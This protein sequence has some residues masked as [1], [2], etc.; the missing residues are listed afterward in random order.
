MP[1]FYTAYDRPESEPIILD[2]T[3]IT[4]TAGYRTLVQMIAEQSIAGNNLI[5]IRAA[6]YDVDADKYVEDGIGRF[7][8]DPDIDVVEVEKI[9]LK[10]REEY[11]RQ[12]DLTQRSPSPA[13]ESESPEE[14]AGDMPPTNRGE[15]ESGNI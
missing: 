13:P 1:K 10:L 7:E 12:Y 14:G 9:K 3:R 15:V 8:R 4:T 5:A 2:Q 11:Y 6:M